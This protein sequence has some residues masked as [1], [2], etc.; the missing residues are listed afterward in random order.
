MCLG[1]KVI[2]VFSA[3]VTRIGTWELLTHM[4]SGALDQYAATKADCF[5]GLSLS[6]EQPRFPCVS[7]G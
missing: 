1:Y 4:L 2:P 5:Q 3:Y 6:K 7:L